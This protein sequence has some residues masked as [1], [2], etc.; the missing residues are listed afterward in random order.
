M[1]YAP[2]L[3]DEGAGTRPN[4]PASAD[5]PGQ[6]PCPGRGRI[7][8]ALQA[9]R[10]SYTPKKAG[11]PFGYPAY[12]CWGLA[13][14]LRCWCGYPG[15]GV[16]HTP[17]RRPGTGRMHVLGRSSIRA[18]GARLG[19]V[20][21]TPLHRVRTGGGYPGK[22][23]APAGAVRRRPPQQPNNPT[24]QQLNNYLTT[25]FSVRCPTLMM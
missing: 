21:D 23:A 6:I 13:A 2:T 11:H 17:S 3:T 19:G 1:R 14:L 22:F 12:R 20:C 10:H 16:L 15:R 5:A 4:S 8:D 18:R 9:P 24:T 25:T 7:A